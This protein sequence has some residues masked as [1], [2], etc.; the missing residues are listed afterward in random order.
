MPGS[1]GLWS[2]VADGLFEVGLE[3]SAFCSDFVFRIEQFMRWKPAP[4]PGPR[5]PFWL[6]LLFRIW[7]EFREAMLWIESRRNCSERMLGMFGIS[8][9]DYLR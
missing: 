2:R 1:F 3:T 5:I 8:G 9:M 6:K 4:W 7:T